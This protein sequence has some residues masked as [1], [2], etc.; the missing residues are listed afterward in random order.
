MQCFLTVSCPLGEG[1]NSDGHARVTDIYE[2]DMSRVLR[3]RRSAFVIPYPNATAVWSGINRRG[4]K[5]AMVAAFSRARLCTSVYQPGMAITTSD[6]PVL[7]S[8]VAMSRNLPKYMPTNW[9]AEKVAGSPRWLTYMRRKWVKA[10][11]R[12][13]L[14]RYSPGHLQIHLRRPGLHE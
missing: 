11:D 13:S 2:D 6:T 10:D 14:Q 5:P 12:K 4:F 3:V 1:D 8:F 7:S 9:A